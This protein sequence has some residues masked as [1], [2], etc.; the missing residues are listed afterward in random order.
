MAS[1]FSSLLQDVGC[2]HIGH[3][4]ARIRESGYLIFGSVV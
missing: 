1:A 3:V 4:L 2:P